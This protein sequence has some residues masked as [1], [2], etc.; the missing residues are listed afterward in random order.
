MPD[1]FSRDLC[2]RIRAAMADGTPEPAEILGDAIALDEQVR[3]AVHVDVGAG[4]QQVLES[5]LESARAAIEHFHGGPLAER[6]GPSILRYAP[7]GFYR[8][9]QDC[10]DLP[11]WPGA[12]RRCIAL[13][14]F[15]NSSRAL[16]PDGDF[17]GGTLRLY[18]HGAQ[19][20]PVDIH[21]A[22]GSLVAF[23][24]TMLHEVTTVREGVRETV[25][26]WYYT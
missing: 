7:G 6:E 16:D 24:A 19:A 23:A 18:P 2:Q 9:H 20:A 15:L 25:V 12:A 17:T 21:P 14:V 4:L 5:T 8:P 13:V 11:G 22:A 1:F 10:G 26:D 3:R